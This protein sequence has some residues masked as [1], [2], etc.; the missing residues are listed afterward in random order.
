MLEFSFLSY[1]NCFLLTFLHILG[2]LELV[3]EDMNKVITNMNNEVKEGFD[4]THG[5]HISSLI[6]FIKCIVNK[7]SIMLKMLY[8]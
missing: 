8:N 6:R 5:K 3:V 2:F 4:E 1:K 7:A